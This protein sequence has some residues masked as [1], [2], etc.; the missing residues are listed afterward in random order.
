MEYSN[1]KKLLLYLKKLKK[2]PPTH[3]LTIFFFEDWSWKS[4]VL[5]QLQ[6]EDSILRIKLLKKTSFVF[7]C[8]YLGVGWGVGVVKAP[9]S[10]NAHFCKCIQC[11]SV[12]IGRLIFIWYASS[13][14]VPSTFDLED[15]AF[16]TIQN[17]DSETTLSA[18]QW[19]AVAPK[20]RL[21]PGRFDSLVKGELKSRSE[22]V[23]FGLLA[24]DFYPN[25]FS[26]DDQSSGVMHWSLG[27]LQILLS[28]EGWGGGLTNL[29]FHYHVLR[30]QVHR[31][32]RV[33]VQKYYG[34]QDIKYITYEVHELRGKIWKTLWCITEGGETPLLPRQR[35]AV[36]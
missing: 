13:H 4:E 22:P 27:S 29:K 33:G 34:T 16:L 26:F 2:P 36:M 1:I 15:E 10:G 9:K 23:S 8:F 20:R 35:R 3:V 12:K 31:I 30:Y 32:H 24:C 28:T 21:R 19:S 7:C 17:Q 6:V 11:A 25:F 18:K 14:A 5:K